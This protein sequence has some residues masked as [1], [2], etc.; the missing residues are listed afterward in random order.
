MRRLAIVFVLAIVTRPAFAQFAV[1][2]HGNL[3]Q[4]VLIAERTLREYEMLIQQYETLQRMSQGLGDMNGYRVPAVGTTRHNPERWQYGGSWLAGL[5]GGD[6]RGAGYGSVARRLESP[7]YSLRQLPP[8]A[9]RAVERAYA[10]VEISDSVAQAAGHQVGLVREYASRLQ[11]AI[12]ALETDIVSGPHEMTAVLD[13]VAAGELVARRQDMATNQLL[14][15]AL[16]QLLARSKRLRDTEAA[17]M[18]MRLAGLR[19]GRTAGGSVVR[20]AADDLRNWRQP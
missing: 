5:N 1:V 12:D 20:G 9:R 11:R 18:N 3:A 14:A 13:K 7:G 10:T 19:N 2:D 4:A 16:E 6:P 17:T 8:D 15:H